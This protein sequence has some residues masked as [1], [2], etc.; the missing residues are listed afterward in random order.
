MFARDTEQ[1]KKGADAVGDGVKKA[2]DDTAAGA[3][4]WWDK[5]VMGAK[6]AMDRKAGQT[7][8]KDVYADVRCT[9][10]ESVLGGQCQ[11]TYPRRLICPTCDGKGRLPQTFIDCDKCEN[12]CGLITK[13]CSATVTIPPGVTSGATLRLKGEGDQGT[14]SD[15]DL[16]VKVA[17]ESVNKGGVIRRQGADLYTDVVVRFPKRGEDTS[18]RVRTVEGDWGNLKVS[19]GATVGTALRIAGRGAQTKAGGDDRGDHFFVITKVAFDEDV[20][21]SVDEGDGN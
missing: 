8:G 5:E 20:I 3:K 21:K 19:S 16:Y 18:V 4:G 1:A 11:V 12:N 6:K 15:G 14:P 7:P 9:L 13:E 17:A 10:E 2:A